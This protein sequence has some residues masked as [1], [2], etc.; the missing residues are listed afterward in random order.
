MLSEQP[1]RSR[2]SLRVAAQSR[3]IRGMVLRSSV[4]LVLACGLALSAVACAQFPALDG[5]VPA[6]AEAADY[7]AL[8][9][10]EPL[11]ANIDATSTDAQATTGAINA[12]VARLK[13]RADRL[14]RGVV[15]S[16]TRSRM[17]TGVARADG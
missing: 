2:L 1:F 12:R 9:P 7:P 11:L 6:N 10:L 17:T 13:S 15:D 16:Q 14:R 3:I 5:T 4:R 8:V